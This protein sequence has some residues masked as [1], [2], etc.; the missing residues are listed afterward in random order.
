MKFQQAR[1]NK[2]MTGS[3]LQQS[4][5][6]KIALDQELAQVEENLT[7]A[8]LRAE[9]VVAEYQVK[10]AE[11]SQIQARISELDAAFNQ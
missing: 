2:E 3:I 6:R 4:Q 8:R 9:Q 7:S 10:A 11:L 1:R 5:A